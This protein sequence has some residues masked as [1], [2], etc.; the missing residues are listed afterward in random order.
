[1]SAANSH[2]KPGEKNAVLS[3]PRYASIDFVK[4]LFLVDEI[5][6]GH[7]VGEFVWILNSC[8]VDSICPNGII[9]ANGSRQR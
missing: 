1:M 4:L 7:R 9:I 3:R 2:A 6:Y 5:V 8:I